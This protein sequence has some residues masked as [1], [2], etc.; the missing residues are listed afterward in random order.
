MKK[1]FLTIL[2][3]ACAM[4]VFAASD[5]GRI[6]TR[7]INYHRVGGMFQL[8][9]DL[10]L[11]SLKLNANHQLFVTPVVGGPNGQEAVMPS[12]LINGRNMH[13]AYLR[14]SLSPEVMNRYTIVDEVQRH[15]GKSQKIAYMQQIPMQPWMYDL[16]TSLHL[17]YDTCG[18]GHPSGKA[19]GP[20]I[21]VDLNPAPRMRL[22][23]I[24]PQVTELPVTV[25]EGEARVQFEVDKTVLHTEPYRTRRGNQ[26]IDNREQLAIIIDSVRY[27]T[28]DPNV[29]IA[30]IDIC[31][32]ASPESPYLHNQ[33]LATD[34]SRALAEYLGD[35]FNLPR[36]QCT[37]DAVPENWA[38]FRQM[39]ADATDI[40]ERQRTDLLELID[41]PAYGPADY[42]AKE[43]TLKTDPRFSQLYASKILPEWFPRLRATKF[44]I[45]TRLRP[46]S[47]EKLAEII[48]TTPEL[49]SL[50]QM[51]RV[52]RLYPEGSDKFN[53]IIEI[54]LSRYPEDPVANLNAAVTA[55]AAGQLDRAEQLLLKAGNSPEAENARGVIATHRGDFTSALRHF[56]AA[57]VL[58][59]AVKNKALIQD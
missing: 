23:Q 53:E 45:S 20:D 35:R 41:T 7:D 10:V 29:E 12:V 18:C 27:A 3:A 14:G 43:R 40:T 6:I 31:G 16:R 25:H 38:E 26:L 54:A 9:A 37:Y 5:S 17:V 56:E 13:Y 28:T 1:L 33:Q 24:T 15:N 11:D 55:I 46:L 32:Y 50:N 21:K 58:P 42:D 57:G 2:A 8:S 44:A 22:C 59:E 34:R 4:T 51:M 19:I 30:R 47:D 48:H 39:V 36:E 52:A 49:M